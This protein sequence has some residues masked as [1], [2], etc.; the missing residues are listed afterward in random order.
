DWHRPRPH[1]RV[2]RR[3]EVQA[4]QTRRTNHRGMT[5]VEVLTVIGIIVLLLAI[6]LPALR[7]ARGNSIWA[8]SQNNLRQ[9][10]TLMQSYSTDNREYI[11]PSQFDYSAASYRGKVRTPSPAGS[12]L[13]LGLPHEGTW[14]DILW[15]YGNFGPV[16]ATPDYRYDSPDR[17]FYDTN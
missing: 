13:P 6:L 17:A 7:A 4:M 12:T 3:R 1:R 16:Q 11:V 14:T 15:T 10:A 2:T 9:I 5:L 8:G